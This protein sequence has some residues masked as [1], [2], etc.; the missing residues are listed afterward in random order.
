MDEDVVAPPLIIESTRFNSILAERPPRKLYHYTNQ[1]GLLGIVETQQFWATKVQY[2]ND[3]TEFGLSLEI[4]RELLSSRIARADNESEKSTLTTIIKRLDSISS[5]NICA[6]SFCVNP[7]L[8]SQWRAYSGSGGGYS[9]GFSALSLRAELLSGKCRLGRC[10]YDGN[11]Q[12]FVIGELID[13]FFKALTEYRS[14]SI[15]EADLLVGKEFERALMKCGAFFKDA[16]FSEESEW[17]LV[18]DVVQTRD[19]RFHFR[20]G[21][22]TLIPY[23]ALE[24]SEVAWKGAIEDVY[25]GPC[26]HPVISQRAV[27]GLLLQHHIKGTGWDHIPS[28][29][30]ADVI[31]SRIPFRNW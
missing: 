4:A 10:I 7:D 1:R 13:E 16:S 21:K 26:P 12:H 28:H 5:V 14:K 15:V 2:M 18:T 8:L 6:V 22:S 3:A 9:I 20:E 31:L 17:R 19:P 23:Y 11:D 25:I 27:Q 30:H 24:F 29:T